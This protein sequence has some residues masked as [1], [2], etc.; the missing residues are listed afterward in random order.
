MRL[1]SRCYAVTGLG[2]S[3]PWCVN[4]GFITGDT[5]TLIVD[6]AVNTLAAQTIYGYA[7]A[8][9]PG[10]AVKALNTEGHFDHIGGNGF[11]RSLGIDVWAH[12]GVSRTKAEFAAEIAEFNDRTPNAVRRARKEANA[13][14]FGTDLAQPNYRISSDTEFDLGGCVVSVLLT[15]GHTPSNISV[16]VP[17]D[18]VLFTGD[19]LIREYLPSL[20]AGGVDDWATWLASLRR[21]EALHPKIVVTG[22]GPVSRAAEVA[23]MIGSVRRVLEEAIERGTSPTAVD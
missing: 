19:C 3:T 5:T 14:F 20:D 15:P 6:T 23:V 11:F 4:A 1:S 22:H 17:E 7:A 13:F 10:N 8:V 21:I 2:Y 12:Q 9:R 18:G 16:W